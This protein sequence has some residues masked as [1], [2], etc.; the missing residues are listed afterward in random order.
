MEYIFYK[1]S[2]LD[3]SVTDFYIGSTTNFTRRKCQ[4]KSLCHNTNNRA[5]NYKIYTIIRNNGGWENWIMEPIEKQIFKTKIDAR[6]YER[7]LTDELNASL[8]SYKAFC[9]AIERIDIVKQYQKEYRQQK[10]EYL[11]ECSSKKYNCECGGN[12]TQAN[13]MNHLKTQKHKLWEI[14]TPPVIV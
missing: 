9:S 14:E 7:K 4:H 6:I 2:C 3:D 12:Y 5:Y 10:K 1:I 11:L 8:N 13:K